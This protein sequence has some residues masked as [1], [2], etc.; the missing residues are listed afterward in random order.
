MVDVFV[1]KLLSG[2]IRRSDRTATDTLFRY[3][4]A[5]SQPVAL[6]MPVRADD[7]VSRGLAP[8]FD[9]NLPEGLLR[10]E[11]RQAFAKTVERMDDLTLL[12]IVGAS[13]IGRLRCV[14]TGATPGVVPALSIAE[15]LA[16]QGT[17]SLFEELLRRFMIYSGVAGVQ[18]KVLVRDAT[19]VSHRSATHL[20]KAW[21]PDKYPQLAANEHYCMEVARE[22]GLPTAKTQLSESGALLVVERFDLT[23][24]GYLGYED[25]CSL[26]GKASAQKYEGSYE[27]MAKRI[28]QFVSPSAVPHALELFFRSLVVSC[29]VGN[30]DAHLKNFGVLYDDPD[31]LVELTPVYDVVCTKVYLP[32]DQ[33]AL[34]LDGNR[35]FPS[36]KTLTVF[37][38]AS[39]GLTPRRMKEI[40]AATD[41]AIARVGERLRGMK[42]ERPEFAEVA[43]AMDAVWS[44]WLSQRPLVVAQNNG[45][46]PAVVAPAGRRSG[47]GKSPPL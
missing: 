26:S 18:P 1:D 47:R 21:A 7:Y 14:P 22:V 16:H 35:R 39:C 20:V 31:Q 19:K 32:Q 37:G 45:D 42:S 5:E 3:Q 11:L 25:F 41:E 6:T 46:R 34:M 33:L 2:C 8:V 24:H 17:E 23:A 13:Q 9:M 4:S 38:A 28:R 30:G 43:R 27:Q 29:A 15:L 10:E 12:S 44:Q 36:R 40:F